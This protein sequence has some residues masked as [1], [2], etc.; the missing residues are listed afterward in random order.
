MEVGTTRIELIY[1]HVEQGLKQG[2]EHLKPKSGHPLVIGQKGNFWLLGRWVPVGKMTFG[3]LC[4]RHFFLSGIRSNAA[5][6]R[7]G[8]ALER[9]L[10]GGWLRQQVRLS[11]RPVGEIRQ[12]DRSRK[13]T[14]WGTANGS[15]RT[16]HEPLFGASKK[17]PQVKLPNIIDIIQ[18]DF[19]SMTLDCNRMSMTIIRMNQT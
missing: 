12:Q 19:F 9:Q 6:S 18:Q 4:E 5:A 3:K 10:R 11:L 17:S 13:T 15:S 14:R 16:T 8:R 1:H 2:Q 7:R